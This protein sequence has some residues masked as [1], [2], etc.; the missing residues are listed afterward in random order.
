M[1]RWAAALLL[2]LASAAV[3]GAERHSILFAGHRLEV[4]DR[5]G[6]AVWQG[7]IVLGATADLVE[8]TRVSDLAGTVAKGTGI[9]SA[10]GRWLRGPSGLFEVAYAVENDPS[11]R[12]P[13]TIAAFNQQ[14]AGMFRAVPRTT[15]SDYVA[16]NFDPS[17]TTSCS[18]S[19]GRIGGRQQI[20]GSPNCSTGALL[21]EI[22]HALGMYHEQTRSD[23]AT[24]ITV[25]VGAVDPSFAGNY[26]ESVNQ[27]DLGSYDYGSLMHYGATG[28]TK[29]GFPVMD[30]VPPGIGIGQR[31]G[32]SRGDI[33]A[34]K[35][36]YGLFDST[37][38]IDTFPRGLTIVVDGATR[39]APAEFSWP[40]GSTHTLDVPTGAQVLDG[41]AHVF[42]RWS[43]DAAGT[44]ATRHTI[45]VGAGAGS[46][47]EP[48]AFPAVNVYTANFVRMK[49]VRLATSG[50]RTGIDGSVIADPPPSAVPGLQGT[51]YRE[52]QAFTLT[53]P[54]NVGAAFGRWNGNFAFPVAS[55]T[56]HAAQA[57]GPLAFSATPATYDFN[58]YFVDFPFATIRAR[59]QDGDIFGISATITR[60]T[61]A[62]V[63]QRLPYATVETTGPWSAGETATVSVPAT[64]RPFGTSVRYTLT[65]LGAGT[66]P[67]A[68]LIHPAAGQAGSVLVATYNKQYQPFR[69]VNPSCAGTIT[70]G[71]EADGWVN[72][73]ASMSVTMAPATGWV[74][75]RWR[76]S[77]SGTGDSRTLVAGDVPDVVADMNVVATP[78]MVSEVRPARATSGRPVTLEIIG[79]GFT[80]S[81]RVLVA[82]VQKTPTSIEDGR[83]ILPLGASDFPASGEVVVTVQNRNANG[84][85][86]L[87]ISA[88]F[89]VLAAEAQVAIP[90]F[91]YSDLWWNAA[92]PGWGLNLIQHASTVVYG[93][94][95]TYEDSGKP[96]WFVM[97]GGAWTTA[98]EYAGTLYRVTG[99]AFTSP[100]FNPAAVS[101]RAAGSATLSFASRDSGTFTFSVD[102]RQVV[103]S[104]T[105]QPF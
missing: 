98:T 58:A 4:V 27:R 36:L 9:G 37:I 14:L 64:S 3:T 26:R 19:I 10:A 34:L 83:I 102:G 68:T 82:N 70:L 95:Y 55:M 93:V 86:S 105:R 31:D 41:V 22:G 1:R 90:A 11:Q 97:P 24:W 54:A 29:F 59:S 40:I 67:T 39:V 65:S 72:A 92:E 44:L 42:A 35:R 75:A 71:T 21:H 79:Q 78:L 43:N 101:V 32:Y 94:M 33:D 56:R 28:F 57:R 20:T 52:R 85:C 62:G 104:I 49:E 96:V 45:T 84:S 8:T 99:P 51:Y 23:L 81:S 2:A 76:G 5:D 63:S 18:S 7:D 48:T 15:E 16:F 103:K 47:T 77:L 53:G 25:D 50:S 73:G 91:D 12:V 6:L 74:L 80:S 69:Q 38:V 100:V 88:T 13:A 87:N 46:I 89:E 30:S 60:G 66:E 17:N 61:A